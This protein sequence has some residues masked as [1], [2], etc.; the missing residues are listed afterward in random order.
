VEDFIAAFEH[1]AFITE[2]NLYGFFREFFINGLKYE[3][4]AHVLM[5]CP[6]NWLEATQRSKEAQKIVSSQTRKPS[7]PPLPKPTNY[8]PPATPLKIQ[9]LTRVEMVEHQLKD[10]CCNFYDKYFPGYKCK[11][12]NIFMDMTEDL[13]EEYV[14]VPPV[15]ELTLPSDLTPPSDPPKFDPVISLNSLT[16]FSSPRTLKLIGYIKNRKFIILVDSGS[17]H[18]FIHR[19]ISQEFNCYIGVVNNFQIMITNGGFIKCGGRCENV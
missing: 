2:G 5:A 18:N 17:T 15:E 10:L 19:R 11:E 8:S 9:K 3:M 4:C 13:S 12:Q 6:Q 16:G 14:V 1:L 7:F